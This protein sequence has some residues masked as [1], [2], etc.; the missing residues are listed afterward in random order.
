MTA[1]QKKKN[2]EER[3]ENNMN[4]AKYDS[5]DLVETGIYRVKKGK[6]TSWIACIDKGWKMKPD[7][8][9]GLMM[10][11]QDKTEKKCKSLKEARNARA[12]ARKEREKTKENIQSGETKETD[13][14]F[15]EAVEDF[16]NSQRFQQ[17]SESYQLHMNNHFNHMFEFFK[18]KNVK[19]ITTVDIENYFIYQKEKGNLPS[20]KKNKDGSVNKKEG[21][22]VNTISKHKTTLKKM[23]EFMEDSEVYGVNRKV[24][25]RSLLPK[26]T[27][28]VDGKKMTYS[29]IPYNSRTLTMDEYNY[30]LNDA[31]QNEFDRSIAVMI[32]LAGIGSLRTS[33]V[34]GLTI[35]KFRHDMINVDP[36]IFKISGY[37]E[38]F[39]NNHPELMMI[40]TGIVR[41]SGKEVV[42]FPKGYKIRV[43]AIPEPLREIVEYG[44]EQRKEILDIMGKEITADEQ[45]YLPLINLIKGKALNSEKIPVKWKAY[46][47]RRNKRMRKQGLTEIPIIRFHDLRHTES[48]SM[49]MVVP[50]FEI[51]RNM[52]H[53]L[54]K[55]IKNVTSSVYW[56]DSRPCRENVIRFFNENIKIDWDKA[57]RRKINDEGSRAYIN[58]SGHLVVTNEE[59]E[60]RKQQGKK[61]IFKEEELVNMLG[62]VE[63]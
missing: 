23:W 61:F 53:D 32:A 29:K 51:S 43:A 48:D 33:E 9:T 38:E 60:R 52:G 36:E 6:E 8:K 21:I 55:E 31:L 20:A 56:H 40:D 16:R 45:V 41:L 18:G 26:A 7:K 35:G 46:Q 19:D 3:E 59:T 24:V 28:I 39:Y 62:N 49:K 12:E 30:T 54:P 47:E 14:T 1:L 15:A 13:K 10:P 63:E 2:R 57:M 50:Q 25:E 17:I 11:K 5:V 22:S 44:L 58:G 37:D 42:Q 4:K 34:V 27:I